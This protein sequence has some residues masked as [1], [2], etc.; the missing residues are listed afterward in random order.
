[1]EIEENFWRPFGEIRDTFKVKTFFFR[2]HYVFLG[3][4]VDKPGQ[5]QNY[6]LHT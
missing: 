4:N 1:M 6:F 3:Q 5:I 2:D